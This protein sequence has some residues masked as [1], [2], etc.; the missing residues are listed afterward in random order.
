MRKQRE[1][2]AFTKKADFHKLFLVCLEPSHTPL[3]ASKTVSYG[4]CLGF[5]KGDHLRAEAFG[6]S[7]FYLP[8]MFQHCA[9]FDCLVIRYLAAFAVVYFPIIY[10]CI[11]FTLFMA[12]L[13]KVFKET[14]KNGFSKIVI[15][16]KC[17]HFIFILR[18]HLIYS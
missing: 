16:E 5:G 14:T 13:K 18:E 15:L 10:K 8:L 3:E 11:L 12:S 2:F 1:I 9:P 7:V 17:F 6:H 4:M